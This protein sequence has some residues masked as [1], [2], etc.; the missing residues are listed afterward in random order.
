MPT[1]NFRHPDGSMSE[2]HMSISEREEY[3]KKNPGL[4]P[5]L[6]SAPSIG[7]TLKPVKPQGF[8]KDRI[9]AIAEG[10]PKSELANRYRRRSVSEVKVDNVIK[11]HWG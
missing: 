11:K 7:Y 3:L 5:I 9:E 6:V 8:L 1:Y 4:T 10:H 2:A